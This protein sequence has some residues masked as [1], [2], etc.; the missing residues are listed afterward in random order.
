MHVAVEDKEHNCREID[1]LKRR[2]NELEHEKNV[3][4]KQEEMFRLFVENSMDAIWRLD[5]QLRFIYVSSAT[6]SII[7]FQNEE[8]VG[9]S[10]FSILTPASINSVKTGSSKRIPLQAAGLD[11]GS[12]IYTVEAIHK[13]GHHIWVEVTVNPI[14]DE[15]KHLLGYNGV[16]RDISQRHKNEEILRQYA[17]RDPLTNLPN[18]RQFEDALSN[19]IVQKKHLDKSFA[20]MF[21]DIDGLKKINDHYGHVFGD[22]LLKVVATRLRHSVRNVDF[23]ARLAGDEFIAILPEIGDSEAV[24]FIAERLIESCR[25]P[26]AIGKIT[27][28]IGV[29]VGISFFPTDADTV[30]RLINHADQAMYNV[31][32]AGGNS[33]LCYCQFN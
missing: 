10:L 30:A 3:L 7:G 15:N 11:W 13:D 18:R 9:Q 25:Q 24:A 26:I 19:E 33:F 14:F 32:S 22:A 17:F 29:S 27:V 23:V 8:I 2:V 16:T 1:V 4:M 21:L 20:V 12:A 5:E 6:K 28:S 31:K